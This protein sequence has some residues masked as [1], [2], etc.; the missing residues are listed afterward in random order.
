MAKAF[1]FGFLLFNPVGVFSTDGGWL[2]DEEA[3]QRSGPV[4]KACGIGKAPT[5]SDARLNALESAK[6]EFDKLCQASDDCADHKVVLDPRRTVCKP[7]N[8]GFVCH[9]LVNFAIQPHLQN[10]LQRSRARSEASPYPLSRSKTKLAKGMSKRE[11]M[12][13][14]GR[15]VQVAEFSGTLSWIYQGAA[16]A[17]HMACSVDFGRDGKV[18]GLDG[19]GTKYLDLLQ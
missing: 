17:M 10:R 9:R 4:I 3:S 12:G 6:N 15:P 18:S 19:V 7:T 13:I 8:N 16:C 2:C 11:V 1:L 14:L 5:E